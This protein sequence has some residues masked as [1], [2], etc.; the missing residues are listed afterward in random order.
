[1][2]SWL[3]DFL[4]R[5]WPGGADGAE[6]AGAP[7]A[8]WRSNSSFQSCMRISAC[9]DRNEAL[10]KYPLIVLAAA[11]AVLSS[12]ATASESG[13][14]SA[15]AGEE[16]RA[17]KS[18]SADDIA[19]LRRGGGWGLAKAA[20]LNGMPGPAHLLEMKDAIALDAAQV[21]AIEAIHED[22][23]AAAIVE[24]ERLIALEEALDRQFRD[25]T[26]TDDALLAALEAIAAARKALRYVHLS[27]HLK[28]PAIL[29]RDQI[30]QYNRLRGYTDPDPCANPPEGHDPAMW[31]KHNGCE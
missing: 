17:I 14:R 21:A 1:M 18:L 13:H 12:A 31:R 28:T 23:K 20:E 19:E 25:G 11:I 16:F 27:T 30:A 26:I 15:Y 22:M 5:P 29:S 9:R 10:M 4:L 2:P 7:L 24:G 8:I 3:A 6:R